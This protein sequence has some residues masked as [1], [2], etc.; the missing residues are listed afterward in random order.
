MNKK[1]IY[2]KCIKC[3]TRYKERS[4][5]DNLVRVLC[6]PCGTIWKYLGDVHCSPVRELSR[7]ELRSRRKGRISDPGSRDDREHRDPVLFSKA[8]EVLS[9]PA[10]LFFH[11]RDGAIFDC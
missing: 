2:L 9:S 3:G 6:L 11:D 1:I 8:G 4:L 5:G 7:D 10:L